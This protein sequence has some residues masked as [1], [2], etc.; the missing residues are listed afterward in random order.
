MSHKGIGISNSAKRNGTFLLRIAIL[1]QDKL[2][3]DDASYK[4][5]YFIIPK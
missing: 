4:L 3:R 2:K 5:K 1:A